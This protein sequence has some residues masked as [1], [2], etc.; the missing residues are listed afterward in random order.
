[1]RNLL[2]NISGDRGSGKTLKAVWCAT[3]KSPQLPI[4]AN[5]H[6]NLPN[7]HPLELREFLQDHYRNCLVILDEAY[8]YL[9]SRVSQRGVNRIMGYIAMQ[10]RKT[11]LDIILTE[12]VES[13]VDVRYRLLT[14]INISCEATYAGVNYT[15]E[16]LK[17]QTRR[18]GVRDQRYVVQRKEILFPWIYLSTLFPL[19][20]TT[21]TIANIEN[22]RET[23]DL[24]STPEQ[25]EADANA[26][27]DALF[28]KYPDQRITNGI[29]DGFCD[30]YKISAS[31]KRILKTIVRS[32]LKA[33]AD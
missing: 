24:T 5:F 12:Q 18:I 32:R 2:I 13:S 15:Y 33:D 25:R 29:I 10:S 28:E 3:L 31:Q 26:L 8:V 27:A 21:E 17:R 19:F 4:Y 11:N 30:I 7:Y 9:E 22:M 20:D 1:V 14:D 16:R 6:I 23:V